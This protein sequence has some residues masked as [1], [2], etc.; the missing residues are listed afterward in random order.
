MNDDQVLCHFCS[1]SSLDTSNQWI[2]YDGCDS[3]FHSSSVKLTDD[4]VSRLGASS[5]KWFCNKCQKFSVPSSQVEACVCPH[6]PQE[7]PRSFKT[8]KGLAI[9]IRRI[10]PDI[11]NALS[12]SSKKPLLDRLSTYKKHTRILRQIPKRARHLATQKLDDCVKNN[13][14]NAWEALLLFPYKVFRIP[15][16]SKKKSKKTSSNI[17][18]RVTAKVADFDIRGAVKLLSSNDT[19]ADTDENSYFDL[20]KKHPSPFRLLNFPSPLSENHDCLTVCESDVQKAINSFP[21]GS[22]S[23]SLCALKKKDGGLRPIAVGNVFRRLTAKLACHAVR[24]DVGNY[25]R[26]HQV[27]FATFANAP[28]NVGKVLL[29]IDYK[30]AFN[31]VERDVM[32]QEV[33]KKTPSLFPFLWQCYSFS[34]DLLF[35]NQVI[36]S[37]VGVQQGDPAGPMTFSLAIPPIIDELKSELNVFY[38]DDGTLSDDPEV[39]LSDFMNIIDRSQELGLQVNPMKCELYFCSGEVDTN[40]L[41][42]FQDVA[43]GIK[44]VSKQNLSLLGAPVFEEVFLEFTTEKFKSLETMINRLI[45]L[46]SHVAYFLLK[47]CFAIPKL[48]YLLRTSPAWKFPE[49]CSAL[50]NQLKNG[51]ESI[52]NIQLDCVQW[53]QASLPIKSGGLGIR[54]ITD[55]ALPAFLASTFGEEAKE[56]WNELNPSNIP[57]L[58]TY[59]RNWDIINIQRIIVNTFTVD[60]FTEI[61]RLKALQLPESGAWLQAIPSSHIGTLMDNNSFRVCVALRIGSPVCRP[62]NCICGAQVS[63]DGR[64]GLHCGK[65]SGRFSRH[66]ELNDIL[67]RSLSSMGMPCLLEP[68]GP[69]RDDEKRPDGMTLVPWSRGQHLVWDATCTDTLADSHVAHSAVESGYA[70]EAAAKRKHSKYKVIKESNYFFVAFAVETFGPCSKEAQDLVHTIGT[71]LNQIYG[72]SRSKQFLT[73]RISLALPLPWKKYFI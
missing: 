65:G 3:W 44:A 9:H 66:N 49:W 1:K 30:N 27:G 68:G 14:L 19:L 59:Q 72:D 46:P 28:K 38:L 57:T 2:F 5:T 58:P 11:E 64:H 7:D 23:A 36:P 73:Q 12:Q 13:D 24:E 62:Y 42:C 33:S 69:V 20:K 45:G 50:D 4:K 15:E 56:I 31:S 35:G 8:D 29:K 34:I 52:L 63:V 25:F 54:K 70:A 43:P 26:P 61:A 39:V 21:S 16:K 32:L 40:I 71:N 47:N 17:N 18:K 51:L 53:T 10:H 37:L 22:A 55:I 6:C 67:K 48:T 60:S 41:T